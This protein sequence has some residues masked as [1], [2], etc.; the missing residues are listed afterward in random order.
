MGYLLLGNGYARL[1]SMETNVD[2]GRRTASAALR[3]TQPGDLILVKTP[4]IGFAFGR[5]MTRNHYDHVAVDLH[6]NKTLSIVSLGQ[7]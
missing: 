5:K 7:T 1:P 2:N 6:G 3:N 4:G